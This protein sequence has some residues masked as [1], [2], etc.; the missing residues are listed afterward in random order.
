LPRCLYHCEFCE[1][2][3]WDVGVVDV[4]KNVRSARR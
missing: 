3:G 2:G 1:F 4:C